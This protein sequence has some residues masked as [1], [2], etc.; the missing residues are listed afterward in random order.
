MGS[1]ILSESCDMKIYLVSTLAILTTLMV[2]VL[3]NRKFCSYEKNDDRCRARNVGNKPTYKCGLFFDD[4]F[5][6]GSGKEESLFYLGDLPKVM[7]DDPNQDW[8]DILGEDINV[9]SFENNINCG[10]AV[11]KKT[12]NARCYSML[13]K[14]TSEL[15][16]SCDN[17]LLRTMKDAK[18]DQTPGDYLCQK[19]RK[20]YRITLNLEESQQRTWLS[21]SVF[22]SA[23]IPGIL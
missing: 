6:K 16:D 4:L 20:Q 12:Y 8:E 23:R 11:G 14:F 2:C 13:N 5:G 9:A 19:V 7:K 3:G 22:P 17:G 1:D 21:G 18:K 15:F 10:S